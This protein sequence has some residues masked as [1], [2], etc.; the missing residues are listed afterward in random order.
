MVPKPNRF[1]RTFSDTFIAVFAV[2]LFKSQNFHNGP[3]FRESF[4][5]WFQNILMENF[6]SILR[7]NVIDQFSVNH[8]CNA[9]CAMA[10]AKRRLQFDLILQMVLTDQLLKYMDNAV[11]PFQMAGTADTDRY[12][13]CTC[14]LCEMSRIGAA[15]MVSGSGGI[16]KQLT[17]I[18]G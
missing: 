14:L 4:L 12:V 1:Y 7:G 2:G 8:R 15:I 10:K 13:Q 11:G 18:A 5:Q 17:I 9:I 3:L 16:V 6:H